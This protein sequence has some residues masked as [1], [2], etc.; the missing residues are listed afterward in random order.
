MPAT[1]R[2]SVCNLM[3]DQPQI[4]SSRRKW[5][6]F[7]VPPWRN[8]NCKELVVFFETVSKGFCKKLV[9]LNMSV[10]DHLLASF[11]IQIC[12][13]SQCRNMFFE[14]DLLLDIF[15]DFGQRYQ[16]NPWNVAVSFW[17][18][19]NPYSHFANLNFSMFLE[20]YKVDQ[21]G[22]LPY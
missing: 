16:K 11:S 20:R 6:L 22:P 5:H 8:M 21:G 15:Q 2:K 18:R 4:L 7:L 9:V 3:D 13:I 10:L 19:P 14:W 17:G 12:Q 1:V